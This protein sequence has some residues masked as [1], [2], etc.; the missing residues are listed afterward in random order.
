MPKE[1]VQT[2]LRAPASCFMRNEDI[3]IVKF[4]DKKATG[5]KEVYVI[6]SKG[7]AETVEVERFEKGNRYFAQ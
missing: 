5:D 1:L 3:L 6:D 7:T 2:K 4:A